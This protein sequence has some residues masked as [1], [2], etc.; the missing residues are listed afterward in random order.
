MSMSHVC[1]Y[2]KYHCSINIFYHFVLNYFRHTK[3]GKV[4]GGGGLQR[5]TQDLTRGGGVGC[6]NFFNFYA[7][8]MSL[9]RIFTLSD[10]KRLTFKNST[11]SKGALFRISS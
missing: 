2:S 5:T 7:I 4:Q 9:F 11:Q 3:L 6:N 1:V 8:K 10:Y